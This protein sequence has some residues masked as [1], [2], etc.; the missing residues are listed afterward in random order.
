MA[1]ESWVAQ[2]VNGLTQRSRPAT[3]AMIRRWDEWPDA[4]RANSN[5][6]E[7]FRS[8][9]GFEAEFEEF[10]RRVQE[11]ASAIDG[12]INF[13]IDHAKGK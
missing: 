3:R 12:E 7:A 13:R 8:L 5:P 9:A 1:Y 6:I 10:E 11:L 2:N 4:T